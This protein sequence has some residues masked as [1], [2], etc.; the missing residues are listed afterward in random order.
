[1]DWLVFL[2]ALELGIA[3]E[4][5]F[6]SQYTPDIRQQAT[7]ESTWS[8]YTELMGGARFF[9]LLYITGTVRTYEM[10]ADF[11]A[12]DPFKTAYSIDAYLR[13]K[14]FIF[15]YTHTCIHVVES[16]A[17]I[18]NDEFLSGSDRFYFRFEHNPP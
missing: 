5:A 9:D 1:M 2:F 8:P 4:D 15:G 3:R 14:S 18:H 7:Y 11:P 6:I 13:W 10:L 12:F 16:S 17:T